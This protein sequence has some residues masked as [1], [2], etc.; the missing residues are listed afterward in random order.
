MQYFKPIAHALFNRFAEVQHVSNITENKQTKKQNP[1]HLYNMYV[2]CDCS[3]AMA[4]EQKK[5][6]TLQPCKEQ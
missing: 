2:M 4:Q 5:L 1:K 6:N 3:M